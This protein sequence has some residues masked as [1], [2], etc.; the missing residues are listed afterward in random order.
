MQLN[1]GVEK[2]ILHLMKYIY[3]RCLRCCCTRYFY[4]NIYVINR[5]GKNIQYLSL[6]CLYI[7]IHKPILT[8]LIKNQPIVN[9]CINSQRIQ[10]ILKLT[11]TTE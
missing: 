9:R 2:R 11:R 10:N 4:S 1:V 6:C 3:V 5:T 8:L 7:Y